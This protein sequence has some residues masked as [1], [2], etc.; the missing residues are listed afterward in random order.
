MNDLKVLSTTVSSHGYS[1]HPH[2]GCVPQHDNGYHFYHVHTHTYREETL[3]CTWLVSWVWLK[4][5]K[6]CVVMMLMLL[7]KTRRWL[8]KQCYPWGIYGGGFIAC[9][10]FC[11]LAWGEHCGWL[12]MLVGCLCCIVVLWLHVHTYTDEDC[13]SSGLPPRA[14]HSGAGAGFSWPQHSRCFWQCESME[15]FQFEQSVV[16]DNYSQLDSL[17]CSA[18]RV[19]LTH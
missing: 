1:I 12:L 6:P 17:L 11:I 15:T 9:L 10:W 2:T 3:P 4:L 13:S 19:E 18:D 8:F 16:L 5:W 14:Q 7:F